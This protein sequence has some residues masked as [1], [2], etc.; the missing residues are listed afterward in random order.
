MEESGIRQAGWGTGK[1]ARERL[2]ACLWL[3]PV[4]LFLS[5]CA[6]DVGLPGLYFDE[7]NPDFLVV[8]LLQSL[9]AGGDPA[10]IAG[11]AASGWRLISTPYIGT[12]PVYLT[13]PIHALLG[14]SVETM[15]LCHALFGAAIVA[16][17]Y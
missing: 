12:L 4:A 2:L 3:L 11:V 8:P 9:G 16:L 5:L 10:N 17:G 15:R 7:V 6:R 1:L 13:A 14:Y